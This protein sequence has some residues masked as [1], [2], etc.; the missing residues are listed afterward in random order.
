MEL[1]TTEPLTAL[2]RQVCVT[3]TR[4]S[5]IRVTPIRLMSEGDGHVDVTDV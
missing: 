2:G 3:Y 5:L 4:Q 1:P